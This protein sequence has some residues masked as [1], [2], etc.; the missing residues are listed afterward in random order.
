MGRKA[1]YMYLGFDA[2]SRWCANIL[3]MYFLS[4]YHC[5]TT[6]SI[7]GAVDLELYICIDQYRLIDENK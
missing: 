5:A 7:D 2:R 3:Q 1:I 4:F 6:C